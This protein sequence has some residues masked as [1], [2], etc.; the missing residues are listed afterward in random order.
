MAK[1]KK[2]GGAKAHRKRVNDRNQK[3]NESTNKAKKYQKE[4]FDEMLKQYEKQM[5]LQKQSESKV[6]GDVPD[7]DQISGVDGPEV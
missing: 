7:V 5:E 4:Q 6:D 2:R 3:V 1:S